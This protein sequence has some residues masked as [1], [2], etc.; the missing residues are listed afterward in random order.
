MGKRREDTERREGRNGGKK[1]GRTLKGGKKW[2]EERREDTEGRE[3][4]VGRKE[5]GH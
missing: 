5:G 2:W 4:M 3:E 1:G